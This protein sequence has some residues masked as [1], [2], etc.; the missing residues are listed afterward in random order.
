MKKEEPAPNVTEQTAAKTPLPSDDTAPKDQ[1][2]TSPQASEPAKQ[3]EGDNVVASSSAEDEQ[4]PNAAVLTTDDENFL[5]RIASAAE[6]PRLPPLD[7]YSDSEGPSLT[8]AAAAEVAKKTPL[9]QSPPPPAAK[10]VDKKSNRFSWMSPAAAFNRMPSLRSTKKP[11]SIVPDPTAKPPVQGPPTEDEAKKE[12]KQLSNI[13]EGLKL[14]PDSF[15]TRAL[16]LSEDTRKLLNQFT[17]IL[18]DVIN[19][20]PHAYD[21]LNDF[22]KHREKQIE[23]LYDNLP[24]FLQ[25]LVQALPTNVWHYLGPQVAAGMAAATAGDKSKAQAE[26]KRQNNQSKGY[27]PSLKSL[28]SNRSAVTAM[29]RSIIEFLEARFP[30][31]IAGTNVLLSLAVFLLLFVFWYCYKRGKEERLVIESEE[32]KRGRSKERGIDEQADGAVEKTATTGGE[33]NVEM[34]QEQLE[35]GELKK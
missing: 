31:A 9:P 16:S 21:D 20:A 12:R 18:K 7:F 35:T 33:D 10:D 27:V 8:E 23:G 5:S 34:N 30:A 11:A 28:L 19:G 22:I 25:K 14:S 4:D 3:E 6:E 17:Q 24:P 29:L 32:S 13:L 15:Q 2:I 1:P 26:N